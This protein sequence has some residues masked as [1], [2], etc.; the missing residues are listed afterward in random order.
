[1]P[2]KNPLL[3]IITPCFNH[4]LYLD[5]MLASVHDY[6]WP[7]SI[8]HIIVNDGSTDEL[9]NIKFKELQGRPDIKLIN[10]PNQGLART[11]NNAIAHATGKYI[12]PLDADN[13]IYPKMMAKAI[14]ILES[15]EDIGVVYTDAEY[16]GDRQGRWNVEDYSLG[17]ILHTNQFDAC[18]VVRKKWYDQYGGY[19]AEMPAM[20]HEDWEMWIR[21]GLNGCR[22]HHLSEIGFSYR[23]LNTSMVNTHSTP[24]WKKNRR[25]IFS[26]NIL[27][28]AD[29]YDDVYKELREESDEAKR[30]GQQLANLR[31]NKLKGIAKILLNR[32]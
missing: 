23:V 27:A 9:T 25:Y 21:L 28:I 3:S 19:D 31:R 6:S 11:R 8:E 20:G 32:V 10:Q 4:G 29:H 2:G 14:D 30:A 24:N 26:K 18:A 13:R 5:E 16:F 17:K 7:F 22:F 15:S 12:L 1:M